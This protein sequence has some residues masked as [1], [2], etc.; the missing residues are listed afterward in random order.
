[1][2]VS[3]ESIRQGQMLISN[4]PIPSETYKRKLFLN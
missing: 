1:M 3:N 4:W 2:I